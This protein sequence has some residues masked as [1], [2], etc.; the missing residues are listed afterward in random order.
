MGL[1]KWLGRGE[2]EERTIDPAAYGYVPRQHIRA[3][4]AG[5][6]PD[7]D[8]VDPLV[9]RGNWPE[10][11]A[12]LRTVPMVSERRFALL[13]R[14]GN[15]A[16]ANDA[17]LRQWLAADP[18]SVNA[19]CVYAE[20]Q[21]NKAWEIRSSD[22]AKNV[23]REQWQ[24][25]FRVLRAVPDICAA[26]MEP[27]PADPAPFIALQTAAL[28]LRWSN[29]E[30][31]KLWREI[32]ARAPHSFTA[33]HRA[34][35]YWRPRWYGSLELVEEFVETAIAAAPP[36]SVLTMNR[37]QMLHEEF[38]PKD[39]DERAAFDRGDR[40]NR[41][42][43]A[44]IADAAA[45][46]PADIKLP[47]LRHWLAARLVRAGRHRESMNQFWAV[48]GYCGAEPWEWFDDPLDQFCAVRAET[49]LAWEDAGRP[50]S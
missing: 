28:G 8:V 42:L 18:R 14:L 7:F 33:T 47:Y 19:L 46:D 17:W 1:R 27:E 11:A 16:T 43:S 5:P 29:D 50:T 32:S 6:A 49:T 9:A 12:F 4:R 31:R 10:L 45:A 34:W 22:W 37:I 44:G 38:R 21:V 48:G 30:Y 40:V 2:P 13:T 23:S 36:G 20:S 24:G 15:A 39:G 26:A 41:A 3:D 35:N 25:F